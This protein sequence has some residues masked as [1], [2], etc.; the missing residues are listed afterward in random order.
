MPAKPVAPSGFQNRRY[1]HQQKHHFN[2]G[3]SSARHAN[4]LHPQRALI[5]PSRLAYRP[6]GEQ[7]QDFES[8]A[9]NIFHRLSLF[10]ATSDLPSPNMPR[11]VSDIKQFIEICRR[12]DASCTSFSASPHFLFPSP[13]RCHTSRARKGLNEK[14]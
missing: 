4:P 3:T 1:R 14:D 8:T 7:H 2:R 10:R 6:H 11:E 12:K 5:S 13:S 9:V